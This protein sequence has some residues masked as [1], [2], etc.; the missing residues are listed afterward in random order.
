M[1]ALPANDPAAELE[2][3]YAPEIRAHGRSPRNYRALDTA[4]HR[5]RQ[6]HP[7]CGEAI[8]VF[9]EVDD[10]DRLRALSF[11]GKGSL[12]AV[13]SASLMTELMAGRATADLDRML[14]CLESMVRGE[15]PDSE[16]AAD[17]K[18]AINRLAVFSG[19]AAYPLRRRSA[20]LPWRAARAALDAPLATDA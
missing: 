4:T 17:I 13:A 14:P 6:T 19:V 10:N 5:A 7:A 11:L 20:L 3:L 18:T 1:P 8:E 9:L 15:T 2:T 16:P 12:V